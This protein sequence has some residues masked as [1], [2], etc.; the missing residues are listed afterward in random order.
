MSL[1]KAG[2]NP[3][4][5]KYGNLRTLLKPLQVDRL[6]NDIENYGKTG[7]VNAK[8]LAMLCTKNLK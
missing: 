7:M 8:Q 6:V 2:K 5:V 3:I 4:L 1:S